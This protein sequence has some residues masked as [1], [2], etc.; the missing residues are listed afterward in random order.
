MATEPARHPRVQ[1]Q[2]GRRSAAYVARE[3]DAAEVARY[4]PRLVALW[5]AYDTHFARTGRRVLFVLEPTH[6]VEG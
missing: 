4:W 6:H 3:A 5:P 1:V 2:I